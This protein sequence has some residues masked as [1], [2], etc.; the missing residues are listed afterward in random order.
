MAAKKWENQSRDFGEFYGQNFAK[1]IHAF[2][3]V[4][5]IFWLLASPPNMGLTSFMSSPQ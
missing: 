2:V 5:I 4:G 3:R 1:V